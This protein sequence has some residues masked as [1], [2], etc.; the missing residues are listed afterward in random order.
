MTWWIK[1]NINTE[2]QENN[3]GFVMPH[4]RRPYQNQPPPS[5]DE[6]STSKE[7]FSIFKALTTASQIVLEST[8][9]DTK[10]TVDSESPKEH[11]HFVNTI[12]FFF[13]LPMVE[14]YEEPATV[15]NVQQYY[16]TRSKGQTSQESTPSSSTSNTG[17]ATTPKE[18]I[19]LEIE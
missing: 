4:V 18:T 10:E 19:I 6:T 13:E 12:S 17:K 15:F 5:T 2:N 16:N 9:E 3:R 1:K 7:I 14:E 11:N 8:Y